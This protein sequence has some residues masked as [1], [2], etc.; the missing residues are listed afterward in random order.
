MTHIPHYANLKQFKLQAKE[1]LKAFQ[2]REAQVVSLFKQFHSSTVNPGQ[3]KLADAQRVLAKKYGFPNWQKA[4]EAIDTLVQFRQLIQAFEGGDLKMV[5]RIIQDYPV[6]LNR[7]DILGRAVRHGNLKAVEL[8]YELGASNVQ[9][10]LGYIV[11]TLKPDVATFLLKKGASFDSFDVLPGSE[12]LNAE[13]MRFALSHMNDKLETG[14]AKRSVAMLLSTYSRNPKEKHACLEMIQ[15]A[16]FEL[17]NTPTMAVHQG[18]ID[19]LKAHLNQNPAVLNIRFKEDDFYPKELGIKAGD[20]LHLTPLAGTTLL[21]MAIAYDEREIMRF[22][23]K[24]GA[25]INATSEKD[26]DGFGGH[27]P[28]FHTVVSYTHSDDTKAKFLLENGANPNVR[29]TIRKQLRYMGQQHLEKMYS[30]RE[31]TPIGFA[32][33][34]QVQDW[35]S[36]SSISVLEAY[37]GRE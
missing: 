32:R 28:L 20:G 3:I 35:V 2:N 16:G 7:K 4:C 31:V 15:S 12:V 34:F 29:A 10:A 25:N 13:V 18:K 14:L 9:D 36:R 6:L 11:Y 8:M 22:L 1:L 30:F 33:Q 37:G 17:P 5:K 26:E 27:T 19:L 24:K 21:H 23:I